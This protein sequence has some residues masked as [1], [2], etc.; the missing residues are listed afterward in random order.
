MSLFLKSWWLSLCWA[1]RLLKT[2][3]LTGHKKKAQS[4]CVSTDRS[5]QSR[6]RSRNI[7]GCCLLLWWILEQKGVGKGRTGRLSCCGMCG[8]AALHSA[9][10]AAALNVIRAETPTVFWCLLNAHYLTCCPCWNAF[11]PSCFSS[12]WNI[13]YFS[14]PV[15]IKWA[16]NV[17]SCRSCCGS[18]VPETDS[19]AG[20]TLEVE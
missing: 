16:P 19:S 9:D 1:V 2:L 13:W 15:H 7:L 17:C 14:W 8:P 10:L 5:A 11:C 6:A 3:L 12:F 20:V 4:P 18:R